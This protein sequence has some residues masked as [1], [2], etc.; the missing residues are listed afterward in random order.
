M[1]VDSLDMSPDEMVF[2]L[3]TEINP[4]SLIP[5]LESRGW[6]I[7]S[8]LGW[9]IVAKASSYIFIAENDRITLKGFLPKEIFGDD[10]DKQKVALASNALA[11]VAGNA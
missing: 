9:K 6:D 8:E 5:G 4:E 1:I 2:E 10:S 11:L 7:Q 3:S